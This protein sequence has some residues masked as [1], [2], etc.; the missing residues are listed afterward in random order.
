MVV[1][2][3]RGASVASLLFIL[4]I[5]C[6]T[7]VIK[8]LIFLRLQRMK[9]FSH[10]CFDF[11]VRSKKR[12]PP[13]PLPFLFLT[14]LIAP[15]FPRKSKPY[16]PVPSVIQVAQGSEQSRNLSCCVI[17]YFYSSLLLS[18]YQEFIFT[19]YLYRTK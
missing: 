12:S 2:G 5:H 8:L 15:R 6:Y 4:L 10:N 3:Q 17:K 14:N 16:Q 7:R 18:V 9:R 1:N 19:L 13:P 11:I